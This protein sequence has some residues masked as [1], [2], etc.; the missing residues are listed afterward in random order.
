MA[1]MVKKL[2]GNYQL[3]MALATACDTDVVDHCS[4]EKNA[5]KEG[6]IFVGVIRT[7]KIDH[8]IKLSVL[9]LTVL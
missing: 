5:R 4:I 1:V 2:M 6:M 9:S 8:F 3:D 7:V